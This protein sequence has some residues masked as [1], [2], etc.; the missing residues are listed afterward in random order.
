MT[1][2]ELA[3]G[4]VQAKYYEQIVDHYEESHQFVYGLERGV[5]LN[6]L[7]R[8]WAVPAAHSTFPRPRKVAAARRAG[9]TEAPVLHD[10]PG[11]SVA[12]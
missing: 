3:P 8:M 2:S 6:T 5:A 7:F 12:M 9:G 11:P 10:A 4:V 1:N